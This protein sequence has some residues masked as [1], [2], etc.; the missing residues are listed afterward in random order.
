MSA[1]TPAQFIGEFDGKKWY[2]ASGPQFARQGLF[3]WDGIENT[4]VED[5]L[6]TTPSSKSER[7]AALEEA[8]KL[9]EPS[10]DAH[11]DCAKLVE[12]ENG[13]RWL[14][15]CNCRNEGDLIRIATWCDDKNDAI[16]I[17]ALASTPP[18]PAAEDVVVRAAE[19]IIDDICVGS[20][21][22]FSAARALAAANLLRT[23]KPAAEDVV[24]RVTD[25]ICAVFDGHCN[26]T[27]MENAPSFVCCKAEEAA[28]NLR[29]ANLLRTDKEPS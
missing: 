14:F 20:A 26:C 18:K 23:D 27:P 3:F 4:Y 24:E 11:C 9:I 6:A 28:L 16:R 17:R 10:D 7:E 25:E 8:A 13:P 2:V 22:G 15:Q 1:E 21:A 12:T 5:A 19:I 29:R